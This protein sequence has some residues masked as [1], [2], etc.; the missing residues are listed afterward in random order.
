MAKTAKRTGA[1][2]VVLLLIVAAL[3][4]GGEFALRKSIANQLRDEVGT[5]AQGEQAEIEFSSTPLLLSLITNTIPSVSI[6]NPSTVA[7]AADNTITGNPEMR[8]D[9]TDLDI[10]DQDAPIA[11][12]LKVNPTL[13][14][15]Y[16]LATIQQATTQPSQNQSF[17]DSIIQSMVKV[18]GMSTNPATNTLDIEFTDGAGSMS[19]VPIIDNGRLSF[20]ATNINVLGLDLPE[21]ATDALTQGLRENNQAAINGLGVTS[22]EVTETGLNLILEGDNVNLK[23]IS[24][25][26]L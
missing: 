22:A 14:T 19:L 6:H 4:V 26:D 21:A 1:I 2:L 3:L 24:A 11:G 13:T 17:F 5:N 7:I 18:T 9:I 10:S 20:D 8:I 25:E 15:E 16:L 12:H 23:E